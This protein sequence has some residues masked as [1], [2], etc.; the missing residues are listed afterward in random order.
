MLSREVVINTLNE[1]RSQNNSRI[2]QKYIE[3]INCMDDVS[4]EKTL[5]DMKLKSP[6]DIKRLVKKETFR[7][8]HSRFTELNDLISYGIDRHTIHIHVIPNDVHSMMNTRGVSEAELKIINA[9]EQIRGML[10]TDV[11]YKSI[12]KVYAGSPIMAGIVAKTFNNLG[13]DVR[14]LKFEEAKKDGDLRGLY[15]KFRQKNKKKK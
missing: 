12:K 15:K 13:F 10:Q 1:L 4:L 14:T 8:R 5:S 6:R 3:R 2:I 11:R 9:L 7:T